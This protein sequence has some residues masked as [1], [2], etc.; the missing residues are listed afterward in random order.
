MKSSSVWL[1]CLLG[2]LSLLGLPVYV[3]TSP[4]PSTHTSLVTPPAG[5]YSIPLTRLVPRHAASQHHTHLLTSTSPPGTLVIEKRTAAAGAVA[6]PVTAVG[7][8]GYAGDILIGNPP[9]TIT[10]LFDT[11][12]DLALVISDECQGDECADVTHFSCSSSSTCVDLGRDGNNRSGINPITLDASSLGPEDV[13]GKVAGMNSN[14]GVESGRKTDHDRK[15]KEG[16]TAS[17]HTEKENAL[18]TRSVNN[19]VIADQAMSDPLAARLVG[20]GLSKIEDR[21]PLTASEHGNTGGR[22][23]ARSQFYAPWS[24]LYNQSYVDGSWGAGTFVQDRIQVDASSPSSSA[25]EP[26]LACSAIVTF[27][28]V[29]QDNLGLVRAY[30]GQVS[31]L[32]GLTRSSATGRKTFLQELVHQ[33][34][35]AM[36]IMSM[37]LDLQ[38]GSF[39]LG[40]IDPTQY[41]GELIYSPVTDPV[42]WQLSLQ[43]LATRPRTAH[44]TASSAPRMLPQSNVFQDAALIIDSGTSSLLIPTAASEAIHGELSGTYDPIHR[45]WFLP[46]E[47]P[48]LV[49]WIASGQYG[50]VQPYESLIY[51]LEDGRCQSLI[52]ESQEADYWIL[53]DTWLRGL[54]LVYDMAGQGRI[55]IAKAT[56]T[57]SSSTGA[58]VDDNELTRILAYQDTSA[59]GRSHGGRQW[60]LVVISMVGAMLIQTTLGLFP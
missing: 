6:V 12:S 41:S 52:F 49:W 24:R 4:V 58:A 32:L 1:L 13:V 11:G 25:Q 30:E 35:L 20:P 33:G 37:R 43:G 29:V 45:A 15:I 51:P 23:G 7:R 54:Y 2:P 55:G 18:K 31:G 10:V 46:C 22:Q 36:P 39:M 40:G 8:V 38:G 26:S 21:R 48:D 5:M 28:N 47:G 9:Q 14:A 42:T 27:L 53:G 57:T 19:E 56:T 60:T 44:G 59:G 50:V 16:S 34:S 3:Q 17:A